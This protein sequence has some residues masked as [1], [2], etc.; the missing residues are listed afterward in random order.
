MQNPLDNYYGS[1]NEYLFPSAPLPTWAGWPPT[2]KS[3]IG[4][5]NFRFLLARGE[6]TRPR[7]PTDRS[8][9][10]PRPPII[11][12]KPI[13]SHRSDHS[14]WHSQ[15][16]NQH[17]PKTMTTKWGCCEGRVNCMA[18]TRSV[19]TDT[20]YGPMNSRELF[21]RVPFSTDDQQTTTT[22]CIAAAERE[23]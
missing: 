2:I 13:R 12:I 7:R 22:T 11:N 4:P 8:S 5:I 10:Q 17:Q 21:R 20:G 9:V 19:S 14:M 3:A 6:R 15:P 18:Y 23:Q 16:I 1:T